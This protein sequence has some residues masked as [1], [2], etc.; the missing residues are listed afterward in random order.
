MVSIR[1][2]HD[3]ISNS[4]IYAF[5]RFFQSSRRLADFAARC[6]F[7]QAI[8]HDSRLFYES[9]DTPFK[10]VSY[11]VHKHDENISFFR[12]D[13][14]ALHLFLPRLLSTCTQFAALFMSSPYTLAPRA[15]TLGEQLGCRLLL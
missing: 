1:K 5:E 13:C 11:K 14:F 2:W 10:R 15:S 3:S 4:A 9:F 6:R 8:L 7:C 12:R